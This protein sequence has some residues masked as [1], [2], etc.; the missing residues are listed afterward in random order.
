MT[1]KRIGYV[2]VSTADQNTARQLEGQVLDKTFIDKVSG[3]DTERPELAQMLSYV[4]EGDTLLVH[5]LDRLARNLDDLRRLVD[6]LTS[7]GVI[8]HFI[9]E[10]L[11]FDKSESSPMSKLLLSVMGAFAEFERAIIKERQKEGIAIAKAKGVFKGR[12]RAITD[13]IA[14]EIRDR[15]AKGEQKAEIAR[16]LGISRARVY[17]YLGDG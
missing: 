9:K 3:K 13:T 16:Q 2:R 5:S 14:Q 11:I 17:H 15:A 8:V 7:K 4:R 1:G 10:N 12:K 6:D